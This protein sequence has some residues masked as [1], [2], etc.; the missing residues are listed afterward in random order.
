MKTFFLSFL[1]TGILLLNTAC[2]AQK[3]DRSA[4]ESSFFTKSDAS[5]WVYIL[6]DKS[7]NPSEVFKM[8]NGILEITGLSSGYLRTPKSYSN[9]ELTV[10][11]RWTKI[12]GNSGVL[13]HIQPNDTVWPACYQAQQKANDA[14]DII[15]MSGLWARECTDSVKFTVKK[16]QKSNEKQLGEWNSMRVVCMDRTLKVY[17]NGLLQNS[18][19]GLTA[20]K[21]YIGFQDEGKPL[22]FRKL[23][24]INKTNNEK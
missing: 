2:F 14:G 3:T 15:C 4:V 5:N 7:M 6:K 16:M 17:V 19:T 23:T 9:Y 18:I 8:D 11:W 1:S 12:L 20:S 10:E 21:G 13:V 24:I 22:E